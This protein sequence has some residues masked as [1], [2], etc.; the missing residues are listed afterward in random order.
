MNNILKNTHIFSELSNAE[1]N[2]ISEKVKYAKF[3]A[4][5]KICSLGDPG[6]SLFII[7]KG[8]VKVSKKI[9]PKK[10]LVLAR[11]APGDS[12]G[13]MSLF[14]QRTRS[15]DITA[16]ENTETI[17]IEQKSLIECIKT[18]PLIAIKIIA[19]LSKKL[20]H[21][22]EYIEF[23]AFSTLKQRLNNFLISFW[24]KNGPDKNGTCK[25]PFA[26]QE[27]ADFFG[28]TLE[29]LAKVLAELKKTKAI[30]VLKEKITIKDIDILKNTCA[31]KT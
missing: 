28:V 21:A 23:L 27:I 6:G 30:K 24:N 22:N 3:K 2:T 12:F 25:I 4:G 31:S 1:L 9:T 17:I 13:E 16:L 5:T 15:A 19:L 7:Y 8:L 29:S 11:L 18:S 26:V 14:D 20:Q 10:E